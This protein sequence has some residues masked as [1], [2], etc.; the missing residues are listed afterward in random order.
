V[1]LVVAIGACLL[2]SGVVD[3][4][5]WF[6]QAQLSSEG[7]ARQRFVESLAS[8]DHL[9]YLDRTLGAGVLQHG[10]LTD[11]LSHT[12]AAHKVQIIALTLHPES[13][14]GGP[15]SDVLDVKGSYPA[16]KAMLADITNPYNGVAIRQVSLRRP[17]QSSDVDG[18][19]TFIVKTDPRR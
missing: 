11:T 7:G 5:M 8:L 10:Q 3:L 19:V 13:R 9:Q 17:G 4:R 18:R 15:N 16:I 1:R 2:L 12:A 6:L 14:N